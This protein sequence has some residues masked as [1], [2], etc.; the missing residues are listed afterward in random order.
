VARARPDAAGSLESSSVRTDLVRAPLGASSA[1]A[2]A[3]GRHRQSPVGSAATSTSAG[4]DDAPGPLRAPQTR[5]AGAKGSSKRA[6]TLGERC[7]RVPRPGPRGALGSIAGQ[8]IQEHHRRDR[9]PTDE[10][11]NDAGSN[12][13]EQGL[14]RSEPGSASFRVPPRVSRSGSN[15]R[16]RASCAPSS[17]VCRPSPEQ[18]SRNVL[19]FSVVRLMKACPRPDPSALLERAGS[20]RGGHGTGI[21]DWVRSARRVERKPVCDEV[22]ETRMRPSLYSGAPTRMPRAERR[23]RR[24]MNP[25]MVRRKSRCEEH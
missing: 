17:A 11:T 8:V 5:Q 10:R 3:T 23:C 20:S 6:S 9:L 16:R 18:A 1:T 21:R 4:A 12:T 13:P 2:N 24:Q 25:E 15:D 14:S 19:C 22:I 7:R